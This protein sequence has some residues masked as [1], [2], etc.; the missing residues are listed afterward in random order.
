[1]SKTA[2]LKSIDAQLKS[3]YEELEKAIT[4][5]DK[6]PIVTNIKSLLS[7]KLGLQKASLDARRMDKQDADEEERKRKSY[8]LEASKFAYQQA[9]DKQAKKDRRVDLIIKSLEIIVPVAVYATLAMVS[10][11]LTYIDEG[12]VPSE[13][14]DLL[15]N[16]VHH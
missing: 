13:M 11:R 8:D 10:F 12:R 15:K 2:D 14:K 9:Q 4:E 6:K 1:M 16:I 3:E 5:D 7:L